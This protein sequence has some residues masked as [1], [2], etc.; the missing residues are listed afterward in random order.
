MQCKQLAS[1]SQGVKDPK[2]N[3][4]NRC[5]L[6]LWLLKKSLLPLQ[7]AAI[8]YVKCKDS[9]KQGNDIL[10]QEFLQNSQLYEIRHRQAPR[11]HTQFFGILSCS[12]WSR[13][14]FCHW[15]NKE[16]DWAQSMQLFAKIIK[17]QEIAPQKVDVFQNS[18][19]LLGADLIYTDRAIYCSLPPHTVP[20]DVNGNLMLLQGSAELVPWSPFLPLYH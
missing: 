3:I 4:M 17:L 8:C 2:E 18:R 10:W 15:L 20:F 12:H 7:K 6:S 19:C 1:N 13:W 9:T 16:E 14:E 5:I 11:V